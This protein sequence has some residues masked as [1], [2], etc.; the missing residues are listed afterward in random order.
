MKSQV[1]AYFCVLNQMAHYIVCPPRA[2]DGEPQPDRLRHCSG[3][4]GGECPEAPAGVEAAEACAAGGFT[5]RGKD[6]SGGSAGKS[7]WKPPGQN[8]PVRANGN[9]QNA[10]HD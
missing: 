5:G 7:F 8:Q 6:Q 2:S 1:L 9:A 3:H 10:L 4:H